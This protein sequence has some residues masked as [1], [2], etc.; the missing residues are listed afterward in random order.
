MGASSGH[1]AALGAAICWA[2]SAFIFETAG[3]RI[4]SLALNLIRLIVAFPLLAAIAWA[5]RGAALPLDVSARGWVWLA[6]SGV[7]G[8]NFGD[9]CLYRAYL[10]I[11]ARLST[12]MM[13]LVPPL[14]AL[15]GWLMLGETLTR[16]D[17][18]GMALIAGGIAWA[19]LEERPARGGRLGGDTRSPRG[20]SGDARSRGW[21]DDTRPPRGLPG[22][23]RSRV[24]PG[25]TRSRDCLG[26]TRSRVLPAGVA[27]GAGAALGQAGGLVLS[28]I[29][30]GDTSALVATQVR[31]LAGIGGFIVLF[32]AL[33]WWPRFRAALGDRR[34]LG[35]AG[36]GAFF[37]PVCGVTLSLVAVHAVAAGVAASLMATT[38]LLML[39]LGVALGR[40]RISA[41]GLAGAVLAVAG[42]VVL[43]L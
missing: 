14:T 37:G 20:L 34:A 36:L 27:L 23:A 25:D 3:R 33:R 28:K 38:P 13:S 39:P 41:A 22:D 19:V 24:L 32:F 7:I 16:R 1:L 8:F 10:L 15:I 17:L 29:G 35:Y 4:G 43:C 2:V 21:S 6:A 31:V 26:D 12:L 18:A 5:W 40:E 42:V 30:M 11:G 9:L